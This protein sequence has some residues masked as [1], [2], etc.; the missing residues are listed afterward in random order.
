MHY[1][2]HERMAVETRSIESIA[3]G[4]ITP[5]AYMYKWP[6]HNICS[7]IIYL[8]ELLN[9][10]AAQIKLPKNGLISFWV[11]KWKIEKE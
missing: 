2:I 3:K 5:I 11:W 6:Q 1:H 8:L 10:F 4:Q 7:L 9:S